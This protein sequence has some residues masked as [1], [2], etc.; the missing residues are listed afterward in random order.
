MPSA[1]A[2]LCDLFQ[3]RA[4]EKAADGTEHPSQK[5]TPLGCAR[6]R[7][8]EKNSREIGVAPTMR[9]RSLLIL[10]FILKIQLIWCIRTYVPIKGGLARTNEFRR[11]LRGYRG[12]NGQGNGEN[13][14]TL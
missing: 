14:R 7:F 5:F 11:V 1:C 13:R 6:H 2:L 8:G 3:A 4:W 9:L 12:Q 10:L